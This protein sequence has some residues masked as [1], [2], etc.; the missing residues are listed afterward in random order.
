MTS[1][2]AGRF[3]VRNPVRA[4]RFSPLHIVGTGS[5]AHLASYSIGTGDIA[6]AYGGRGV[7]LTTHLP[8]CVEV[9]VTGAIPLL[10]LY[11]SMTW[12]GKTSSFIFTL[13]YRK[14]KLQKGGE[15]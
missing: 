14:M 11:V 3:G 5:G 8:S 9:K 13:R 2:L 12:T 1:L 4:R 7:K 10:P 15:N 6:R